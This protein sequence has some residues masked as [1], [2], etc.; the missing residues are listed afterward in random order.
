MIRSTLL[1]LSI[2]LSAANGLFGMA[3]LDEYKITYKNEKGKKKMA[4]VYTSFYDYE[5]PMILKGLTA[6]GQK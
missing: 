2:F 3:L 1:F 4:S 5:E 6:A